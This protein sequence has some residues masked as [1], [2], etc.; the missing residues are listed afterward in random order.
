MQRLFRIAFTILFVPGMFPAR[1][2]QSPFLPPDIYDKL[3]NEISGDIA[4]DNLRSL[5]MYHAPTG[6]SQGFFD[7]AK[8]VE[9]RAKSYSYRVT[10]GQGG[11]RRKIKRKGSEWND[12]Y[13]LKGVGLRKEART[14]GVR[15][16]PP[17]LHI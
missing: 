13:S 15:R 6:A 2:Q 17:R 14:V 5:V 12:T 3:A 4:Y 1:G 16:I 8:W 10:P 7:E 9:E 11:T